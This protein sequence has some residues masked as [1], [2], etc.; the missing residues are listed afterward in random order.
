MIEAFALPENKGNGVITLNGRMT[1][2]LH[3]EQARQL[4]ALDAAIQALNP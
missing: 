3:L 2:L 1:E 4:V